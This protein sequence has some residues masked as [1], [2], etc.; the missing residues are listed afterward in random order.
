MAART[1]FPAQ[2]FRKSRNS[3]ISNVLEKEIFDGIKDH[4]NVV[5]YFYGYAV[6]YF[7]K[8]EYNPRKDFDAR[9]FE[10]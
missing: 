5:L 7:D 6:E 8:S 3:N 1:Q 10:I 4:R 2:Q 9:R